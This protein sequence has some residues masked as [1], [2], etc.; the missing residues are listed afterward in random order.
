MNK[1]NKISYYFITNLHI[2]IP[3]CITALLFD[4][5]TCFVPILEGKAID[6]LLEG[7]FN[8]VLKYCIIFFSL[9][10]FVQ[11]NRFFK[12]YLV[13][14]FGNKM[15]LKMRTISL[16]TLFTKDLNYFVTNNTGDILNRNL[17]DIYDTTE[18]IRKMTTEV[19]D[20][21]VLLIGYFTMMFISDWILTL[22]GLPFLII[23]VVFSHYMKKIVYKKNKEYKEYVSINKDITLN[24]LNN[25]LY[26]RGFGVSEIY[27]EDYYKSLKTLKRKSIM[28][29][30]FQGSLEPLYL[31]I[32]LIGLGLIIYFG[33]MKVINDTN[34][35]F[36]I[37]SLSAFITTYAF[38]SKKVGKLGKLFNTYQAFKVSW[39]RC[40]DYLKID[41]NINNCF[42]PLDDLLVVDN[43]SHKYNEGF[44]IS[45]ISFNAKIGDIIGICG[46]VRC[47]KTTILRMLSGLY[48]YSGSAKLGGYEIKEYRNNPKKYIAH[49]RNDVS[50]FSDSVENNI[51]FNR[52]GNLDN[53]LKV[54][55][56][57]IDLDEIGGLNKILS[58]TNSN[59]SGGQ[60]KRLQMARE[61]YLD[62]MLILLDDPF[63]SVNRDLAIEMINELKNYKN[64]IIVLVSNNKDILNKCD[65][66]LFI[67]D[68]NSIC[69]NYDNLIN[70]IA[71]KELM[72]A[73]YEC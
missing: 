67:D 70:N 51:T 63:Q 21:F 60:Q 29:L 34:G 7:D 59:I 12:R 4:G 26:Y 13:R 38:V 40:K 8:I 49:C 54:S 43:I 65:N 11:L 61:L 46:K 17:S 72:E 48:D 58:H 42:I 57:D 37:G 24:R 27:Y 5:L 71:F 32:C 73:Q 23:S 6:S 35:I 68:N 53:A 50:I 16:D 20:T 1:Y 62:C 66:I 31:C 41:N 69:D 33:G 10:L 3:M 52:E 36:T 39:V 30:L 19:F 56:L 22:I 44:S 18:G 47:G 14:V 55:K 2:V 45:N 25:E 64:S 28:A 15:S 9:V